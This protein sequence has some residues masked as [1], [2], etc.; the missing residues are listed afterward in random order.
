MDSRQKIILILIV[1]SFFLNFGCS[2]K[3]SKTEMD[4]KLKLFVETDKEVYSIEDSIRITCYFKNMG[5]RNIR[6]L[7][8]RREYTTNWINIFD[9]K[10]QQ[11]KEIKRVIYELKIFPDE[12]DFVLLKP[13]EVY[14]VVFQGSIEKG[15]VMSINREKHKGLFIDFKNSAVILE[16]GGEYIIEATYE[17]KTSWK[18]EALKR[19]NFTNVF[20]GKVTSDKVKIKILSKE[21]NKG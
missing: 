3:G 19:Y 21:K 9:L 17:G 6:I 14:S 7:P 5:D 12:D 13:N 15:E 1:V 20:S 4:T 18:Q 2:T 11:M 10:N 8:W 16:G